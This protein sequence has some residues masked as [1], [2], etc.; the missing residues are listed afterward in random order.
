MKPIFNE[1]DVTVSLDVLGTYRLRHKHLG[2]VNLTPE[3]LPAVIAIAEDAG[4]DVGG[5]TLAMVELQGQLEDA[6]E[7]SAGLRIALEARKDEIAALQDEGDALRDTL[8]AAH[9]PRPHTPTPGAF[10]EIDVVG[11]GVGTLTVAAD[12]PRDL[13]DD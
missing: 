4:A 3:H 11:H 1:G 2:V 9:A 8:D 5:S 7:V 6:E 10:T 13:D 12:G